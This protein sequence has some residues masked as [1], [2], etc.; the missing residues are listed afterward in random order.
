MTTEERIQQ[1]YEQL[2]NTPF[3]GIVW[4]NKQRGI[5]IN[6]EPKYIMKIRGGYFQFP[7]YLYLK[8]DDKKNGYFFDE[9]TFNKMY[10]K[11]TESDDSLLTDAF[12]AKNTT[13]DI[14]WQLFRFLDPRVI[15]QKNN[16]KITH[17]ESH[18]HLLAIGI[19]Y[20]LKNLLKTGS[21]RLS[22]ESIALLK[23]YDQS[24]RNAILFINE[25]NQIKHLYQ[26]NITSYDTISVNFHY[27]IKNPRTMTISV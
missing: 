26:S 22:K 9:H 10:P 6:F 11:Q 13:I 4:S 19:Q 16:Y 23:E 1:I 20:E 18:G 17:E 21:I 24:I 3:R 12:E 25:K 14:D 2:L 8:I 7:K 15:L 27:K 5:T